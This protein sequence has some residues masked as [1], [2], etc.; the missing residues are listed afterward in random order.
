DGYL[1]R[2]FRLNEEIVSL[3]PP[4]GSASALAADNKVHLFLANVERETAG[5][6]A[7]NRQATSGAHFQLSLPAWQ[8]NVYVMIAAVF[9][10]KQYDEALKLLSGAAA[11]VQA[12]NQLSLPGTS[13]LLYVEPVNLSFGELS[14]LWSIYGNQYYPSLLCKLRNVAID[15][16][17]IREIGSVVKNTSY[18]LK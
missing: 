15:S 12:N 17:E 3:Q 1:R 7:F 5:G 16:S 4:A 2:A 18:E 14:N 9:S 11:F 8:L 13:E 10:E 6:I